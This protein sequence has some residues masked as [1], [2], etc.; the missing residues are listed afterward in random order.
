MGNFRVLAATLVEEATQHSTHGP[1]GPPAAGR[2]HAA[3]PPTLALLYIRQLTAQRSGR[4]LAENRNSPRGTPAGPGGF[5][6]FDQSRSA[7]RPLIYMIVDRSAVGPASRGKADFSAGA[8]GR[9]RG[10]FAF[11]PKSIRYAS[12]YIYDS[13]PL[14]GRTGLSRK[15]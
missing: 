1:A 6:R 4:P 15:S 3:G 9:P 14:S 8:P 7:I 5:P 13:L 2:P 12:P 11:P 10:I